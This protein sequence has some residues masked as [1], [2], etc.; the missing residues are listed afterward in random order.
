M[1]RYSGKCDFGDT[2]SI[3]GEEYILNSKI[4]I[5]KNIVPLRIESYKDALPYFPHIV[6]IQTGDKAGANIWLTEKSFVDSEEEASLERTLDRLKKYY[7]R[8]KRKKEEFDMGEAL[9]LVS[10]FDEYRNVYR[11]VVDEV[12]RFG[13]NAKVPDT[14]HL[15][16]YES[17]R[18]RLYEDMVKAGYTEADSAKWCFGILRYINGD[19]PEGVCGLKPSEVSS[20][21]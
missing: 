8:C 21:G 4:Y 13:D 3:F 16:Y 19:V 14:V 15:P 10:W 5:G 6:C 9:G 17:D 2:W 7:R 1:S 11:P 18:K 20:D 12:L